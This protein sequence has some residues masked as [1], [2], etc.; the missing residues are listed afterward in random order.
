EPTE[1]VAA[2]LQSLAEQTYANWQ[3]WLSS[4]DG[5]RHQVNLKDSR[6]HTVPP[7]EDAWQLATAA[8]VDSYLALLGP[9]DTMAPFALYEVVQAFNRAT[10]ADLIYSDEDELDGAGGRRAPWFKPDWSPDT[11]RSQPY[12]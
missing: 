8:A 2:L 12:L 11:L 3:V 10:D 5:V 9:A 1:Y 7:G 4:A 6:I